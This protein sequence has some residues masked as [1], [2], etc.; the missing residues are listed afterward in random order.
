MREKKLKAYSVAK[1]T[2]LEALMDSQLQSSGAQQSRLLEKY[3]NNN[4]SIR[5][6]ALAMK[7]AFGLVLAILPIL[8]FVGYLEIF[9]AVSGGPIQGQTIFFLSNFVMGA[10]FLMSLL[11]ILMAGLFPTGSLMT[12]NSFKMLQILP[13][14][15]DRLK[16]IATMSLFRNVDVA[17]IIMTFGFPVVL[18]IV[19]HNILAFFLCLLVSIL[20]S[21]FGFSAL[22]LVGR[23]ISSVFSNEA[24]SGKKANLIRIGTMVGYFS[25]AFGASFLIQGVFSLIDYFTELFASSSP[26][27]I[28]NIL[29]SLIPFPISQG[30]IVSLAIY[31]NYFSLELLLSSLVGVGLFALIVWGLYKKSIKSLHEVSMT[32]IKL[33]KPA[34]LRSVDKIN[35]EIQSNT[36]INTYLRK[37]LVSASHDMQTFI[38]I[39]MPIIYPVIM[40]LSFQG[41]LTQ[42][43]ESMIFGVIIWIVLLGVFSF[44]PLMIVV[45]LLNM[46]E[47]G[48]SIIASL[49][50]LPRDQ[51][52]AKLILMMIIQVIS[53]L[54]LSVVVLFM[55]S[56]FEMLILLLSSIPLIVSFT[57]LSFE[58]K[59]YLFGKIKYKYILEE[60]HKEYKVPKWLLILLGN[61]SLYLMVIILGMSFSFY[62]G[63]IGAIIIALVSGSTALLILTFVFNRMFPSRDKIPDYQTGGFLRK[64]PI[65]ASVIVAILY[66]I[67][68]YISSFVSIPILLLFSVFLPI[69][70]EGS[71]IVQFLTQFAFLSL[72]LFIIVPLGFKLPS[73]QKKFRDYSENI[74]MTT[75]NPAHVIIALVSFGI[76]SIILLISD[77]V[78]D[79][80][81][82]GEFIFDPN[83]IFGKPTNQYFGWTVFLLMLIPGIWEEVA[84]RGIMMPM[85][86]KKNSKNKTIIIS[87]VIFGV[88][89]IN[90]LLSFYLSGLFSID[91]ILQVLAQVIYATFL[92]FALAYMYLK[93]NSLIPGIILHYLIDSIGQLFLN[94]YFYDY[95][96]AGIYLIVCI[97]VIP[98]ILIILLVKLSTSDEDVRSLNLVE[99]KKIS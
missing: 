93:T 14:K 4:K 9:D 89:H 3:K 91:I 13:I 62:F 17:L 82:F 72:L 26:P 47:S 35:V 27:L 61:I 42:I 92:G 15:T 12:G 78:V 18:L 65:L 98:S 83:V 6:Q 84:F 64:H 19:S 34:I 60:L 1:Y 40:L 16:K 85:L 96:I 29:V 54:I 51:A 87:S 81:S 49:P 68:L 75:V 43:N 28:L 39:I 10:Y 95:F 69:N 21:I 79:T 88:T 56:S 48:S 45:G 11:Y 74:K 25:L 57:L 5:N 8:P 63:I 52:K 36:P 32:E 94:I 71:I 22:I 67:F 46:E 44:S 31:T 23:K 33:K 41:L 58:L 50:V 30:Y 2:Y 20:N 7:F 86:A 37:D 66:I 73:G 53:L 76:F 38:F 99:T 77:L 97:G 59:V 80:L 55:T 90:N 70:L 24:Q